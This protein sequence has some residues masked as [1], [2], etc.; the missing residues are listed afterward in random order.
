MYLIILSY[1]FFPYGL[2]ILEADWSE[3]ILQALHLQNN[4]IR[5]DAPNFF[6]YMRLPLVIW[7]QED[8][9]I[10]SVLNIRREQ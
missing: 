10:M 6:C 3:Y 5:D 1:P 2:V 8:F 4:A 7:S 9:S